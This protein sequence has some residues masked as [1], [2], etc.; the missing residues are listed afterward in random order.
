VYK[1]LNTN[2][3]VKYKNFMH[4][5]ARSCV[6]KVQNLAESGSDELQ[7]PEK[8]PTP[9]RHKQDAPGRLWGFQQT[10]I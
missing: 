5:V 3:K 10:H 8:K 7:W 6:S 1:T 9:K 2:K 4:K